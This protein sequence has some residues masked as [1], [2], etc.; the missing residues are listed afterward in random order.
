VLKAVSKIND[1]RK[2]I[3]F[4]LLNIKKARLE[5]TVL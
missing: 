1:S 5:K 2:R 4:A 3:K